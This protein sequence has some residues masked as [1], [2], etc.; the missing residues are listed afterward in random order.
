MRPPADIG[1]A[2]CPLPI[3]NGYVRNLEVEFSRAEKKIEV[4]ERIEIAK[5][6]AILRDSQVIPAIKRLRS[7]QRIFHRLTENPAEGET[8]KFV[9]AHVQK[10]HRFMFHRVNK[11]DAI[12]KIRSS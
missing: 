3:P 10:S 4:P 7:A 8:E 5:E 6:R 11:T 2:V 9:G 1:L 12:G